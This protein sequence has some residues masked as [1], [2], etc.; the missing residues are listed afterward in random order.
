[1]SEK[2]NVSLEQKLR[3]ELR[4]KIIS[5]RVMAYASSSKASR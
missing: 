3:Q 5:C 1:M 2:V 4:L